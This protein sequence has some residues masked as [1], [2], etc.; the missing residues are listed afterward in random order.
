[1]SSRRFH[2]L[3]LFYAAIPVLA[4]GCSAYEVAITQLERQHAVNWLTIVVPRLSLALILA[5]VV[6]SLFRAV[7]SMLVRLHGVA[8]AVQPTWQF[9]FSNPSARQAGSL[10]ALQLRS[11]PTFSVVSNNETIPGTMDR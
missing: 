1:M 5:F 3:G 11:A 9:I 2:R 7:G 4:G 8:L 10:A 6:Y